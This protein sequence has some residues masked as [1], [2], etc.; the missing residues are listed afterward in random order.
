M[1]YF[2]FACA[3]VL[4]AVTAFAI[5]RYWR[6]A[7]THSKDG[8]G[9][10]TD[11]PNPSP[12]A[13]AGADVAIAGNGGAGSSDPVLA[14]VKH[15]QWGRRV[16]KQGSAHVPLDD[17]LR[18][19]PW[20]HASPTDPTRLDEPD[21]LFAADWTDR[22]AAASGERPPLIF[23]SI[24]SY[25][26]PEFAHTVRT[27]FCNAAN[28]SRV[29]VIAKVYADETTNRPANAIEAVL[30]AS[31]VSRDRIEAYQEQTLMHTVPSSQ[32]RG[33]CPARA[34]IETQILEQAGPRDFVLMVDS[35]TLFLRG[36]DDY[37]RREHAA[38]GSQHAIL[39]SYPVNYYRRHRETILK[40][41][42][43]SHSRH[44]TE[45]SLESG[46]YMSVG[47]IL[48]DEESG[49]P[50]YDSR[51]FARVPSR[52]VRAV[53]WA[54]CM[55]FAPVAAHR[56]APYVDW[57]DVHFGEEPAMHA[58]FHTAGWTVFHPRRMPILTHFDRGYRPV[59]HAPPT[60]AAERRE[61][62]AA[63]A[64]GSA[65]VHSALGLGAGASRSCGMGSR[66]LESFFA[67]WG[68]DPK[69]P[70]RVALSRAAG[71]L[72]AESVP[73]LQD[74]FGTQQAAAKALQTL[75]ALPWVDRT[76]RAASA[77]DP[78]PVPGAVRP[79]AV[80]TGPGPHAGARPLAKDTRPPNAAGI[81]L[82]RDDG[83]GGDDDDDDPFAF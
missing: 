22:P 36:W 15:D 57:H 78:F 82:V 76:N 73:E 45:D 16:E 74:K 19:Q 68:V 83:G 24:P 62:A 32:A 23:V 26:D 42:A 49:L 40:H 61:W 66:P 11:R 59:Y 51:T 2:V 34:Q 43:A 44:G 9:V 41:N 58:R 25:C 31:Q 65:M 14:L 79:A 8:R 20:W 71:V 48:P 55:S 18:A 53:G 12:P 33:P 27:C 6:H 46:C 39:S 5:V 52:P 3:A 47:P 10:S 17:R 80:A 7:N 60:N 37:L 1:D 81:R 35:H 38:C 69:D 72:R 67:L 63:R 4:A 64:E 13:N 75:A 77:A 54:A 50:G 29:R 28:P 30:R 21:R 70:G 56:A